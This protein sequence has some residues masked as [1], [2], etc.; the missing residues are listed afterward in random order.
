MIS[1]ATTLMRI[2][3]RRL[4]LIRLDSPY[5][6]RTLLNRPRAASSTRFLGYERAAI[7]PSS[8][9]RLS[10]SHHVP[11]SHSFN[12]SSGLMLRC[13]SHPY[14]LCPPHWLATGLSPSW[15]DQS[16][17][18]SPPGRSERYFPSRLW[19]CGEPWQP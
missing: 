12:R 9:L 4:P 8:S 18:T 6:I 10:R 17:G 14:H 3:V 11:S 5:D 16:G 15:P 13:P 2:N 7:Q 1:Y 19:W